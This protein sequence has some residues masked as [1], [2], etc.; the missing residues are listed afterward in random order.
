MVGVA[1]CCSVS[2]AGR[3]GCSFVPGSQLGVSMLSAWLNTKLVINIWSERFGSGT[4]SSH[5]DST[6]HTCHMRM[7]LPAAAAGRQGCSFFVVSLSKYALCMV[8][9]DKAGTW[10]ERFGS[11]I[12]LVGQMRISSII[13]RKKG[14]EGNEPT[15]SNPE[16]RLRK[17]W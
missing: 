9:Y 15:G 1:A 13:I 12:Y 10:S 17:R 7:V 16:P 8:E 14:E 3:Q 6:A 5:Y 11:G 2:A 4:W